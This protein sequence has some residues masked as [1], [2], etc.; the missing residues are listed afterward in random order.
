MAHHHICPWWYA[1]TFDNP[2]RHLF[3]KPERML[4]GYVKPGMTVMDIGCGM[5]FFSIGMAR[6]VGE[7]GA[8]ISVDLQQQ[9]LD[10]HAPF[11]Y[12]ISRWAEAHKKLSS[13]WH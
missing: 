13:F 6:M 11:C 10:V 3:H 8:V 7:E 12:F 5:G 9:M 2:L 1:Y 4:A